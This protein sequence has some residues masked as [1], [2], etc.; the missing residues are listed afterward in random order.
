MP[1]SCHHYVDV[2]EVP[3]DIQKYWQQRYD[4]FYR[5]DEGVWMTD[6]A[7]YGV[8]PEPVAQTI[9]EHLADAAAPEKDVLIDVFAGA[10]GNA[11]AF[12]ASGRWKRVVAIEKDADAL[13]CARHN[14]SV[15]GVESKIEWFLGDCFDVLPTMPDD[16]RQHCVIFASPPWGGQS[17]RSASVFDL[18]TMQ[19]YSLQYLYQSLVAIS[20][21]L[22][23]YLPR[24]SDLR[25][26]ADLVPP[27]QQAQAVHYCIRSASKALCVYLL[28][29]GA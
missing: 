9:A 22:V 13:S 24:S 21:E 17:Y 10:G 16:I 3:W 1:P 14:A 28:S 23:L 15:Y 11:I 20:P 26:I 8:T 4:I 7:W 29:N 18:S 2:D 6:D 25:Q 5:Y 27:H 12:A 19:P